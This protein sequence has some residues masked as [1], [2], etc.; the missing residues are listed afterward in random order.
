MNT[1]NTSPI[2]VPSSTLSQPPPSWT[3]LASMT[4]ETPARL[5]RPSDEMSMLPIRMTPTRPNDKQRAALA[6][7]IHQ[8]IQ[9]NKAGV[10]DGEKDYAD[11]QRRRRDDQGIVDLPAGGRRGLMR[12]S[13]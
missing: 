1:P 9:R 6:Q 11:N 4:A 5:S 2:P 12:C 10:H 7:D 8:V 3:M 13:G